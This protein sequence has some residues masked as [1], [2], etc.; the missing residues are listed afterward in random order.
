MWNKRNEIEWLNLTVKH[1][2]TIIAGLRTASGKALE[3]KNEGIE[4][5]KAEIAKKNNEIELLKAENTDLKERIKQLNQQLTENE[6]YEKKKKENA[7][8]GV[9][10]IDTALERLYKLE[11]H[12]E[13]QENPY[14][15]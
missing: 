13:A 14:F 2:D 7:P 9:P 8:T 11:A 1:K 15:F 5:L 6:L 10:A 12:V 3:I 4:K